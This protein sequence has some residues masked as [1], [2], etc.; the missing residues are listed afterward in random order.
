MKKSIIYIVVALAIIA[1]MV[2]QLISN[3]E[4]TDNSV[5]Q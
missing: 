4:T 2:F 3:K 1:L 5:Y